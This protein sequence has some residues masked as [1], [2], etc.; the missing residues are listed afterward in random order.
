MNEVIKKSILYGLV[1]APVFM[2]SCAVSTG[3]INGVAKS[4]Q[5]HKDVKNKRK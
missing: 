1:G 4:V 5:K 2:V 3:I